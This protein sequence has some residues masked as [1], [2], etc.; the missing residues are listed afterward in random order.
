MM[1]LGAML[2]ARSVAYDAYA[3]ERRRFFARRAML[4]MMHAAAPARLRACRVAAATMIHTRCYYASCRCRLLPCCRAAAATARLRFLMR[5]PRRYDIHHAADDFAAM[6]PP[7]Y[8]FDA[9]TFTMPPFSFIALLYF[10]PARYAFMYFYD[11]PWYALCVMSATD[12]AQREARMR[13]AALRYPCRCRD[14]TMLPL[15]SLYCRA[16]E[17]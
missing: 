12:A 14:D 6:M 15:P 10:D 16:I 17:L 9:I 2:H 5:T 11:M 8:A 3:R 1:L 4:L 7:L 13:R